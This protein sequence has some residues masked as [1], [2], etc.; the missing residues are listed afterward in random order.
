[1]SF[2]IDANV[3]LYASDTAS[4]FHD[5]ALT[6]L[7]ERVVANELFCLAWPV[8]MAYLRIATHPSIFTT[9]LASAEAMHNV[10][11]LV[12]LPYVRMLGEDEGF[13]TAYRDAVGEQP[14]RGNLV[15]DAHVAALLKQHGVKTLYSS[16]RD[17]RRFSFLRVVDPFTR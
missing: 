10:E 12:N 16:D 2:S 5:R 3:L 15:S 17:Y 14:I 8:V 11:A 1:M 13:W 9:P 6:F 4:P 7:N